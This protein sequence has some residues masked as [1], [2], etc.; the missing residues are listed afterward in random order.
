M[1]F[2]QFEKRFKSDAPTNDKDLKTKVIRHLREWMFKNNL[3]SE[4]CF[5]TLCRTVGKH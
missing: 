5:D 1:T 3:S 2:E 4:N